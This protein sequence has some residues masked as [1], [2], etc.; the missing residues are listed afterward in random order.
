[1]NIS[2][3]YLIERKR[4]KLA[5]TKWKIISLILI[6]V[7]FFVARENLPEQLDPSKSSLTNSDYIARIKFDTVIN[8]DLA[9]INKIKEIENNNK[10]KAVI[11]HVNSPGGTVV[12]SEMIYNSV[13]KISSSNKPVVAVMGSLATSGG[14][15][16]SLA[17]DHIISHNGTIT[18]SI[19]VIMQS[20]EI[21]ELAEKLGINFHNFKSD[22]LKAS[23]NFV[24]KLTPEAKNA[25][26][27]NIYSVYDF[28]VEIVAERRKMDINVAREIS[29]GRI[30][31]GRQ[32]FN[33]NLVDEIGN[34]DN[35]ISWLKENKHISSDLQIKDIKIKPKEKLIDII[36]EDFNNKISSFFNF[37][38]KG[39]KSIV[40][41]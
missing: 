10:I 38:F 12:G 19:G 5:L 11:M 13:R 20:A 41:F 24:E 28:F 33:L 37:G 4:N 3:D 39:L 1:M 29:D 32:A 21:T 40:N 25:V 30:Y 26:M 8:D 34:E 17:A 15:M 31:S 9:I 16:I 23:P 14:Y 36:M 2:P 7:L 35:A 27:E 6:I 22:E 18:G